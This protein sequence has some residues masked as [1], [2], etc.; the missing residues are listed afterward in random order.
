[1]LWWE[2]LAVHAYRHQAVGAREAIVRNAC[3]VAVT[4]AGKH[5]PYFRIGPNELDEFAREDALPG[6]GPHAPCGYTVEVA[7]HALV[8]QRRDGRPGEVDRLRDGAVKT[9]AKRRQIYGRH[10]RN[11]V[12]DRAFDPLLP[13]RKLSLRHGRQDTVR[14]AER[15]WRAIG[16]ESVAERR[17]VDDAL[18]MSENREPKAP[19]VRIV[20]TGCGEALQPLAQSCPSCLSALPRTEYAQRHFVTQDRGDVFRFAAWLPSAATIATPIGPTVFRSER[21]AG[22]LGMAD[23][24]IAFSGYAPQIGARNATGTFK[25]FEA[26]PTLFYLREHGCDRVVLASAGNTARAFAY[27][28]T[29]LGFA[30]TL[31]VP[32]A[33]ASSVWLPIPPSDSVRLIVLAGSGDY[34]AAIRL[35]GL[36]AERYGLHPEGGARNAARRDGMGTAV[37]EY[38]RVQQ[39]LP[40]HYVQAVGS[41]TGGIAAWEAGMRL[42]ASGFEGP[43][44]QLHLAQNVPFTPIHDAWTARRPIEPDRNVADQLE[45]IAAISAPVLANRTPPYGVGGGVRDALEATAGHTYAVTNAEVHAAQR[46]FERY[47][48]MP[49]GPESGA[50][51]AALGQGV[52]R[53]WIRRA[54]P[55]LLHITGNGDALLKRDFE[56]YPVPV[57]CRVSATDDSAALRDLDRAFAS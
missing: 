45:R 31:V 12:D 11:V 3:R 29:I 54:D 23:L 38:A 21:L 15:Q 1:V 25:D 40:R 2:N 55:T 47:E 51:L 24:S 20:C 16:A 17:S 39:R 34:A 56:L 43:L 26:L 57:W 41:G 48:G 6:D 53:S 35:A 36:M 44:P 4:S 50:A 14:L 27:A 5:P 32:E 28:G 37:L 18:P 49:I 13:R 7:H 19:R 42:R 33:A 52:A 22:V 8:W 10:G 30:T 9:K 46:L